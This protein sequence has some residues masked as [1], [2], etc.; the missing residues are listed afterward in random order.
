[1]KKRYFVCYAAPCFTS[2][3]RYY[4]EIVHLDRPP[5]AADFNAMLERYA[6]L[7][8]QAVEEVAIISITEITK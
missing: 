6:W 5:T 8:R 1:M 3:M 4:N 2:R 7:R